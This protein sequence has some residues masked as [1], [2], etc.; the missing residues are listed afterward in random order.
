MRIRFW[1][2]GRKEG[3]RAG[4]GGEE[5]GGRILGLSSQRPVLAEFVVVRISARASSAAFCGV[6]VLGRSRLRRPRAAGVGRK[7]KKDGEADRCGRRKQGKNR[8][9]T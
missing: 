2:C 5:G 9:G 3:T 7:K 4:E 6:G 8:Q 1:K